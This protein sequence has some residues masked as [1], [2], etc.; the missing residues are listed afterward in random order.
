M[1]M[2]GAVAGRLSGRH[3]VE[4]HRAQGGGEAIAV[5]GDAERAGRAH[6]DD[7]HPNPSRR[8]RSL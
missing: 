5:V 3:V 8:A 7:A 6:S 1:Q 2:I 4:A